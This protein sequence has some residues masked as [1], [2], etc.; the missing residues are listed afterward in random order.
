MSDREIIISSLQRVDRRIRGNRLFKDLSLALGL[1]L[2]FPLLFQILDFFRPFDRTTIAVVLGLWLLAFGGYSVRLLRQNGSLAQAAVS[3]DRRLA[4]NDEIK[5]A[6][7]FIRNPRPS[8]WVDVQIQRAARSAQNFDVDRLYPR[9]IPR[10]SYLA[11]GMLLLVIG[12]SL[13]PF[14]SPAHKLTQNQQELFDQAR[15]FLLQA[16][17]LVP[18]DLAKTL[19]Q[20][21]QQL[22]AGEITASEALQ[23]LQEIQN[24]VEEKDL[25]LASINAGLDEIA[26]DLEKSGDM[27]NVAEALLNKDLQ[28]AAKQMRD[29]A[30]SV[31]GAPS[32]SLREMEQRLKEASG[33]SRPELEQLSEDLKEAASS[34]QQQEQQSA[35][36]ALEQ[37]AVDF[38]ELAEKIES[39]QLKDEASQRLK[40]LEDGLAEVDEDQPLESQ[41]AQQG[42]GW[43]SPLPEDKVRINA[44]PGNSPF[45]LEPSGDPVPDAP[46]LGPPTTLKVQL[47]QEKL[48]GQRDEGTRQDTEEASTRERS[49]IDYRN[50][51]S[52]LRTAQKDVLNQDRIPWEYRPL[53]KS[54]FQAIGPPE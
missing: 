4:L 40:D 41:Q 46:R 42:A 53:I 14:F 20:V 36:Q 23:Q 34:L 44:P 16:G 43:L 50:V 26:R 10:A 28:D 6:Y 38:E 31:R 13:I 52:D 17:Q 27:K 1:F 11:A 25:D 54:Y 5:T 22:L 21:R 32:Q 48:T 30:T 2:I 51:P 45:G 9:V 47:Q 7:W 3:I 18:T 29:V 35:Q 19:E 37:T 49:K 12:V 39:Q 8:A 15:Q 33:H 24:I